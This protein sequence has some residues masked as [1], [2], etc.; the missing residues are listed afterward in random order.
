MKKECTSKEELLAVTLKLA[1]TEGVSAVNM[2]DVAAKCGVALGTVYNY[3]ES[4]E[5]LMLAAMEKFWYNTFHN[6]TLTWKSQT[7]FLS[8]F[9]DFWNF[10]NTALQQFK[11][12]FVC[13]MD[14]LRHQTR[15]EG[16]VLEKKY[17]SHIE[18]S[19]LK[20]LMADK[21]VSPHKWTAD[22][23]PEQFISLLIEAT[24][25]QLR[26]EERSPV[27]LLEL[28]KRTIY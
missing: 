16:K 4:K 17:F 1:E 10:S 24:L 7:D 2:R 25:Y 8:A 3:Y 9:S 20:I 18:T 15:I 5:D 19:L 26:R 12:S 11:T 13:Q 27:F 23:T 28:I 6:S 21:K 14:S 22:F